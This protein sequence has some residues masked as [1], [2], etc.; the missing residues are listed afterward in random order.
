MEWDACDYGG[1]FMFLGNVE[2]LLFA[3]FFAL[4]LAGPLDV[5]SFYGSKKRFFDLDHFHSLEPDAFDLDFSIYDFTGLCRR[6]CD[7]RQ[8]QRL[9]EAFFAVQAGN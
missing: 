2:I 7:I 4:F 3:L 8:I 1:S 6:D 5:T 9:V